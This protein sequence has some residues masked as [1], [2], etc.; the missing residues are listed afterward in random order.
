[1]DRWVVS[2]WLNRTLML[3]YDA[4][5]RFAILCMGEHW[6]VDI[7]MGL[8]YAVV[9]YAAVEGIAKDVS[10]HTA[11]RRVTTAAIHAS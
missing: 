5:F 11:A 2:A 9:A 6:V 4:I 10:E 3:G 1:M 7:L 8:L